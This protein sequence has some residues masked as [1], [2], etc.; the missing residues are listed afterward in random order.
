MLREINSRMAP[1]TWTSPQPSRTQYT[2]LCVPP[3]PSLTYWSGPYFNLESYTVW[4]CLPCTLSIRPPFASLELFR[5]SYH[6]EGVLPS[7]YPSLPLTASV[8]LTSTPPP[9]GLNRRPSPCQSQ[10]IFVVLFFFVPYASTSP[11]CGCV[12]FCISLFSFWSGKIVLWPWLGWVWFLH[13]IIF[14]RNCLSLL[15]W[16][17]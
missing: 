13:H 6:P 17:V 12:M 14:S 4:L 16:W 9:S 5:G 8:S 3:L 11:W 15:M 7:M 10:G 2:S 1:S